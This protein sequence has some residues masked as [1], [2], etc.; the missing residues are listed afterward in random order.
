MG[1]TYD[2]GEGEPAAAPGGPAEGEVGESGP[3]A[4]AT[5]GEQ[6]GPPPG[7]DAGDEG[8]DVYGGPVSIASEERV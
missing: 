8:H 6:A 4:G 1:Q 5:D 2:T 3:P 7:A